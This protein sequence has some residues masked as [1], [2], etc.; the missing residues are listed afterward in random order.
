MDADGDEDDDPDFRV[1]WEELFGSDGEGEGGD[2]EMG[3]TCDEWGDWI[4]SWLLS[5][6]LLLLLSVAGMFCMPS[7][8]HSRQFD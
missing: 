1:E 5:L 4:V 8:L 3:E 2:A 7:Y 6:L